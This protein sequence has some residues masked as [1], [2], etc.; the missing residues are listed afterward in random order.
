MTAL[1]LIPHR[2]VFRNT[3]YG[4]SRRVDLAALAQL[5]AESDE[6]PPPRAARRSLTRLV[7]LA[8]IMLGAVGDMVFV[9]KPGALA[10][11]GLERAGQTSGSSSLDQA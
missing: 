6:S 11:A 7:L 8:L 2:V 3:A 5:F 10:S 4:A 1:F 9:A